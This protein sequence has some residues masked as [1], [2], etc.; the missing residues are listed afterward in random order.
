[1]ANFFGTVGADTTELTN[2]ADFA[3]GNLGNDQY[4]GK[5]G[6]DVINGGGGDDL[7]SGN[8]GDDILIGGEGADRLFGNK[9]NDFLYG[10]LGDDLVNGGLGTDVLYGNVGADTFSFGILEDNVLDIVADFASGQ[11]KVR[12]N[13][14][15]FDINT[16]DTARFTYDLGAGQLKF[17]NVAF[18]QFQPNTTFNLTT[19]LQIV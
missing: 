3:F 14:A 12:I 16:T 9:G 2:N 19:D 13:S 11:D 17:D 10:G 8:I 7:L 15:G 6:N 5:D 1:M 4:S 18:V